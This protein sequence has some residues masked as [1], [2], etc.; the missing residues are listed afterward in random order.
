MEIGSFV[1]PKRVP[2]MADSDLLFK[3]FDFDA[4][5]PNTRGLERAIAAGCK[6]IN[7]FFSPS[8]TFNERNLGKTRIEIIQEYESMLEKFAISKD[9]VR[10]YISCAFGCPFE[11][12]ISTTL[13]ELCITDALRLGSTIVMC[14]TVGF[15]E[16]E[17]VYEIATLALGFT[18]DVSMHFHQGKNTPILTNV[19][20]AYDVGI[21][22]FD[23]SIGGLGGCP[24]IP[25]AGGNLATE[26]I[27][28]WAKSQGID[29]PVT[30][31]TPALKLLEEILC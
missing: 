14:D 28:E 8:E 15:A 11:G 25:G 23:C 16:P 20:V 22:Q 10:I 6:N 29:C 19:Q 18:P 17:N 5:V 4:L 1:H 21:T 30:D 26:A 7:L 3:D 9:S 2:T 27:I 31:V 13:L 12:E 24:F